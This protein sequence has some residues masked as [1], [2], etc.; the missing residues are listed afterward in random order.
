MRKLI[1]AALLIL[2]FTSISLLAQTPEEIEMAPAIEFHNAGIAIA[3]PKEFRFIQTI[4]RF[5]LMRAVPRSDERAGL[6][7]NFSVFPVQESVTAESFAEYLTDDLRQNVMIRHLE[8]CKTTPMPVGKQQGFAH[9]LSYSLRGAKIKTA[10]VYLIREQDSPP[11]RICY[12][13]QLKCA[14]KR[15][16]ELLPTFGKIVGSISLIALQR[17]SE[18]PLGPLGDPIPDT[19]H[20]YR[21]RL[22]IVWS[23]TEAP[24]GIVASQSDY[25]MQGRAITQFQIEVKEVTPNTTSKISARRILAR[26]M[27]QARNNSLKTDVL[28]ERQ[29]KLGGL[30]AYEYVILQ[31]PAPKPTTNPITTTNPTTTPTTAPAGQSA[32]VAQ[33]TVCLDAPDGKRKAYTLVLLRSGSDADAA[34]AILEKLC[35]TFEVHKAPTSVP[36]A[37]I[38]EKSLAP[39]Q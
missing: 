15:Q 5:L 17:P 35:A 29:A 38:P 9:L 6:A 10:G 28:I 4:Q 3:V 33:R 22:P 14:E 16:E 34:A 23:Y 32:V 20:G 12:A 18:A 31:S 2:P 24:D 11:V 13:I 1:L 39:G 25:F 30:D 37:A 8:V 26:T 19:R 36:A 27:D 7:V 21:I